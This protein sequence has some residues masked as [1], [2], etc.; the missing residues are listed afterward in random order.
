MVFFLVGEI[1]I[2]SISYG[3]TYQILNSIDKL[4]EPLALVWQIGG[5]A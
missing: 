2:K 3:V 4:A 5:Y 1:C